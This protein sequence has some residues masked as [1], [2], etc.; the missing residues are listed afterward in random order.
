ML[1]ITDIA[2]KEVQMSKT[3]K[4]FRAVFLLIVA[5]VLPGTVASSQARTVEM[6]GTDSFKFS[7]TEIAAKP[8]E[9]ITVKLINNSSLPPV[10]MSHNFVLLKKGTDAS[11]FANAAITAN[12]NGY[13]PKGM[14][15]E[16]IARTELVAGGEVKSV[17]FKAPKQPGEY[18]YICTF[19][20]HYAAGMVGTLTVK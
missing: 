16:I 18:T 7:I 1:I 9:E 19:P 11:A 17:K 13:I 8:G 15:S 3:V 4:A 2:H 14:T 6:E 20:G 10:A 12:D 5:L